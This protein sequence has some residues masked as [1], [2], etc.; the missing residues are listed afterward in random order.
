MADDDTDT[1]ADDVSDATG[2][3]ADVG[4]DDSPGGEARA[5]EDGSEERD[6]PRDTSDGDDTAADP[7]STADGDDTAAEPDDDTSDGEDT[8]SEA[9]DVAEG[10]SEASAPE[11]GPAGGGGDDF[12][13]DAAE[14]RLEG[15]EE[16]I[17][18]GRRALADVEQDVEPDQE[19]PPI[20]E[21]EG[22]ANAPPG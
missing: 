20:A 14:R 4:G 18:E 17:E 10:A 1:T 15:V 11:G 8:A 13:F 7:E 2:V 6:E 12:D 3:P 21:G 19:G 5:E 22:A 9:E 16:K